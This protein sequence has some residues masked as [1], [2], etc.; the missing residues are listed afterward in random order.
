MTASDFL[1]DWAAM[2]RALVDAVNSTLSGSSCAC[3]SPFV[4]NGANNGC[5]MPPDPQEEL[6]DALSGTETYASAPGNIAPGASSC[7]ATGC[8]TNFASTLIR[9]KNAAGVYVTEGAATFTG[10]TCT[11]SETTGS[12]EDTCKGGSSGQVNGVT[13]CIPYDPQQNTIETVGDSESTTTDGADTTTTSTS[14]TTTCNNGSCSTTTNVTTTVN[15]G[16]PST[17]STTTTEPQPEF[18]TKN[19]KAPQCSEAGSFSGSCASSFVC[20]GD[21]VQC[22]LTKEVYTQHCKLN[23]ATD[24]SALYTSSKGDDAE[25]DND[26]VVNVGPGSF[27]TAPVLGAGSCI[28]DKSITV[29]GSTIELP[30]SDVCQYLAML[31]NVLM[32]IG[33]LLSARII[34][35]G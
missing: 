27:S 5:E 6:C 18:C 20:T 29:M 14:S 12:A 35:R 4:Q 8:M 34:I 9:V 7:N 11:Y 15:G 10:A 16:T 21:A 17:K 23:Q 30:F 13:V 25:F 2:G 24:E 22:A 33:Y 32:A 31:G 3:T 1:V 26:E 28:T 19:P